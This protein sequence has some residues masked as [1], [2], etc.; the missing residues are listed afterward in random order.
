MALRTDVALMERPPAP[1]SKQWLAG[2]LQQIN[3]IFI[4]A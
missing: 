4:D 2:A 1:L 3:A